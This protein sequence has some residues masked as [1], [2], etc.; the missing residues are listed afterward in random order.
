MD[1]GKIGPD[2]QPGHAHADTFTFCLYF[3]NTPIVVDT[4]TSTYNIGKRR[5]KERSTMVHNTVL[6]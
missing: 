2:Y 4:G 6:L 5:D 3:K 1:I